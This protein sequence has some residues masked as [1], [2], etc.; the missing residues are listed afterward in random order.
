MVVRKNSYAAQVERLSGKN[1]KVTIT[2]DDKPL[3]H[4]SAKVNARSWCKYIPFEWGSCGLPKTSLID[5]LTVTLDENGSWSNELDPDG[6]WEKKVQE[7][8]RSRSRNRDI[9]DPY[10]VDVCKIMFDIIV[11]GHIFSDMLPTGGGCP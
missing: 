1:I 5:E 4:A 9:A 11:D 2:K 7:E 8:E 10:T 6:S 3:A